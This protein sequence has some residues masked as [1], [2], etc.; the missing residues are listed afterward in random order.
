MQFIGPGQKAYRVIG[1]QFQ[2][3]AESPHDVAAG[4]VEYHDHLMPDRFY[5]R[6]SRRRSCVID[7]D[8]FRTEAQLH[9]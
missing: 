1:A 7:Y 8:I 6:H 3:R 4:T 5:N 9:R 2:F